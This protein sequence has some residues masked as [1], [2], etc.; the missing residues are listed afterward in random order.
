MFFSKIRAGISFV[1]VFCVLIC[2]LSGC[3]MLDDLDGL[4]QG[5]STQENG[6]SGEFSLFGMFG[7]REMDT[8]TLAKYAQERTVT[9]NAE[10]A[11]V[12]TGFFIDESGTLVT[13]FHVIE[14]ASDISVKTNDGAN[15]QVTSIVDL[16][17]LQDVAILKIDA[18]RTKYFKLGTEEVSTGSSVY[19][20]G[21]S[22][23]HLEG[24]FSDGIISTV[25]RKVGMIDCIQTTAAISSGNSGGPLI[26]TYGEVVGINAFSYTAGE[27]LNLAIKISVLDELANDKNFS[28]SQYREWYDKETNHSYMIYNTTAGKLELSTVHT[29]HY[30]TGTECIASGD[31]LDV[32]EMR[33]GY[34]KGSLLYLYDYTNDKYDQYTEYLSSVGFEYI[35]QKL[36]DGLTFS[37]Y[38][39]E[40]TG[41]TVG[42]FY[43]EETLIVLVMSE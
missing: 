19:A 24:T 20:I 2:M 30:V 43:T 34:A 14:G 36:L 37:L 32:A 11:G 27:N 29:Y 6:A 13:C 41:V 18:T 10:G 16:N 3:Q 22:L 26:N 8:A 28:M 4:L 15:Y 38:S 21:S 9:I 25:S 35:G 12:G 31:D 1:L 40:F 33:I 7:K 17:P 5:N 42:F 39:N 23:G